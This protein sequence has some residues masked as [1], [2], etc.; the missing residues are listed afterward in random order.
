[1][2]ELYT[3]DQFEPVES[4]A[5]DKEVLESRLQDAAPVSDR[6]PG[7]SNVELSQ[8]N[9]TDIQSASDFANPE[10]YAGMRRE[11][12]MLKQMEPSL[13]QGADVETFHQWDQVNQIGHYTPD[14]Y[15]RGYADVYHSY[16]GDEAVA[17]SGKGDGTYDVINGRHRIAVARE[18]GLQKIPAKIL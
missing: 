16:H 10:Q 9:P 15:V 3:R 14:G 11:A 6:T 12:E 4:Q 1:M 5:T 18:A 13:N 2:D 8:I 17:L 7:I